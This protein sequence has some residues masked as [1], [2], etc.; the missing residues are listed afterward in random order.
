VSMAPNL[1][2]AL[3][4][5]NGNDVQ[6]KITNGGVVRKLMAEKKP[7]D[8]IVTDLYLRCL[9]RAPSAEEKAKIVSLLGDKPEE[10]AKGLEDLFWS[11][12]NSQEFMFNH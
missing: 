2:Q 10:Q 6:G 1:S 5:I 8:Q 11:L 12:L 7:V 9:S 4:L 3:S